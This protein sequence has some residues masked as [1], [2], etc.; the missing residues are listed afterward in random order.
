[1]L[2]RIISS[3]AL[4]SLL[5]CCC[6]AAVAQAQKSDAPSQAS[7]HVKN[8]FTVK[9][10]QGAHSVRVW[11]AVPQ[12]DA[13]SVITNFAV[14]SDYPIRYDWDSGGNKEG[15]VDVRDPSHPEINISEEFDLK[16]TEMR[17]KIDPTATRPLNDAERAA[18]S[19][20]LQPTTYVVVDDHIKTLAAQIVGGETNPI[21]AARKLYDWTLQNIDY[22]VKDPDHLKASPV[23]S[24]NY[25]LMNKTGNCT[26]F[27][28][29]FA[30]LAM[31]SGIPARMIYGSLLKP[32][33]N[34]MAIDG[35][36]HCWIEFFAP[37]VGWIPLDASLANIYG[38]E[39][40]L[41]DENQKL[42]ELTTATG[43]HGYDKSKIDYYF[44]N[45]DDRRVV[46]SN[47]RDLIMQPAQDD[48]PVN[49][50]P[51]A[52]VEVD[53]KSSTDFTRQFTYKELSS[54]GSSG[55]N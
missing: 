7:F 52:Y 24:T 11:F 49:S 48:G 14:T 54:T 36:Y 47:G 41:T 6:F 50:L 53:G 29:L 9:V 13:Y 3:G 37:R 19:R 21:L 15:Y 40:A 34:G 51:K 20:Y 12:E 22:W 18:L 26:D 5:M 2:R 35:S 10:P 44:G 16:R 33:L 1:M 42:V 23:G 27:H 17:N 30:S 32:T 46:W 39:F 25:C 55:A 45:I 38:K 31:A 43:Y 4:L 28:S 8:A